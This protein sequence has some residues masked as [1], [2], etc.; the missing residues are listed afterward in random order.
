VAIET[1]RWNV[2]DYLKTPEDR[3]AFIE[4]AIAEAGD[5]PA[6]ILQALGEVV[7]AQGVSQTARDSEISRVGL[8][9][10][11]SEGG[12]PSFATV[13]RVLHAV[14]LQLHVEPAAAT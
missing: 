4:A 5:D 1:T 14:G 9:K 3:A 8:H 10:A 11:L 6:F 2:Q 7:R 13:L 12:N